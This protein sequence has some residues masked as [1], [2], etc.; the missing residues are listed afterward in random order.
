M[1]LALSL[2]DMFSVNAP[3]TGVLTYFYAYNR[4]LP[5]EAIVKIF[6]NPYQLLK[7]KVG[8]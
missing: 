7:P 5:D 1:A 8:F 2:G 3:M 6:A 4:V